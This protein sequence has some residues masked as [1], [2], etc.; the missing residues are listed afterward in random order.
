MALDLIHEKGPQA[1]T[2][3]AVSKL[4]GLSAATLVQRFATKDRLV[5]AALLHAWD[6][7]D[8]HTEALAAEMPPTP[9][10]VVGLLAGLSKG[11]GDIA[12]YAQG[13]MVLREDLRDP[14]LRARGARWGIRLAAI[15]DEAPNGLPEG[16]GRLVI[17]QW[18]GELLWWAF[19]PQGPI[20]RA[21]EAQ[22][23][24]FLGA[25]MRAV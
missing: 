17:A 19:D 10:G 16:S 20:E 25:L 4:C 6:R 1:A 24:R 14:G 2:F 13:L 22:L 23:T 8:A 5:H 11:H 15:I 7:L 18:Q 3:A 12:A 21:V 9:A